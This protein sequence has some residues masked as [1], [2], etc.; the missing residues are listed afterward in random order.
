VVSAKAKYLLCRVS[1]VTRDLTNAGLEPLNFQK[2]LMDLQSR[3]Y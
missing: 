3:Y 1:G 2:R